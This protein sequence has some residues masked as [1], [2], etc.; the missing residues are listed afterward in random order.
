M[1]PSRVLFAIVPAAAALLVVMLAGRVRRR[2]VLARPR[3]REVSV[4]FGRG[5]FAR[6]GCPLPA[7][8]PSWRRRRRRMVRRPRPHAFDPARR[9]PAALRSATPVP[10]AWRR[11]SPRSDWP[12]TEETP[13]PARRGASRR[14]T[15]ASSLALGVLHAC[16]DLGGPAAQPL[17]R[18]AS[19]LRARAADL[20]D[21]EVHS[22]QARLSAVV[23]TLASGRR[24]RTTPGDEPGR[25]AGGARVV[26][27][28]LPW[29][30]RGAE[31]VRLV[32]DATDHRQVGVIAVACSTVAAA[33]ALLA[34]RLAPYVGRD[35]CRQPP[36]PH[37]CATAR[38]RAVDVAEHGSSWRSSP[39]G[40]LVAVTAGLAVAVV[41]VAGASRSSLARRRQRRADRPPPGDRRRTARR[42]RVPR[43]ARARR[44]LAH[45]GRA[46]GGPARAAADPRRVRGDRPPAPARSGSRRGPRRRWST[47]SA[48]PP[49]RSPTESPPPSAT[50]SRSRRCSTPCPTGARRPPPSRRSRG[51]PAS[52]AAVVPARR[53]HA[54]VVRTARRRPRRDGDHLVI[55]GT[56]RV[57]PTIRTDPSPR[58]PDARPPHTAVRPPPRSLPPP[59]RSP[60]AIPARRA[61][62]R[63]DRGQATTE[64]ALVLLA[65]ALV[66]LLVVGWAT[67]GGG[68]GKIGR[69]F[70]RVIDS[71]IDRV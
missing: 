71:V 1:D 54:A 15:R 59:T 50:A 57:I 9:S 56:R 64:Y 68:A 13:S 30:G 41:A 63:S 12:S 47:S 42:D 21:R 22:A 66:A 2:L 58:S 10:R 32:V 31:R 55:A 7:A 43:A 19:T 33:I 25:P 24:P 6:H 37:R 60:R 61:R 23:L 26:G 45:P 17:D 34:G 14:A 49:G 53:V 46:R 44:A 5:A 70:D 48:R 62:L 28:D 8:C 52:R 3:R 40:A 16:A 18:T 65:A 51:T 11:S 39:T 4:R 35:A 69:L 36:A 27:L 20:A 29:R 38:T 67:A